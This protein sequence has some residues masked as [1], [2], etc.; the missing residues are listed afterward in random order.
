MER[1]F[2]SRSVLLAMQEFNRSQ[3]VC[4]RPGLPPPP[5]FMRSNE[6]CASTVVKHFIMNTERNSPTL[7]AQ[8]LL[9]IR[10]TRHLLPSNQCAVD[11][12]ASGAEGGMAWRRVK[13]SIPP[14]PN[15]VSPVEHLLRSVKIT[16]PF[17]LVKGKAQGGRKVLYWYALT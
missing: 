15:S 1:Q 17:F 3:P 10:A 2:N 11:K 9:E 14:D 4:R 8:S 16:W 5:L 7:A 6:M 13:S 12:R